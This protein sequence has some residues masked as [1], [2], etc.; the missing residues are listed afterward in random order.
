VGISEDF[1]DDLSARDLE[2]GDL[3]A[4]FLPARGML[5][6]SLQHR[7]VELLRRVHDLP[8]AA[9]RKS[10]AGIPFLHPWAN[11]LAGASYRAAGRSVS[12]DLA[13]PLLHL[14][15]GGL[16]I[17]GVSW[18]L[19][20]WE[21]IEST[22]R[23]L[24]AQL[25]WS[26]ADLLAV[27]PFRH[28]VE[29]AITLGAGALELDTT[30]RADLGGPVPVSFGFHPY[31]G[32]PELPRAEWR[33]ALPAMRRLAVDER[34]IPTGA[35]ETFAEIDSP[36]GERTFDDGFALQDERACFSLAGGGRRI[37]VELMAGYR[38]AQ[39]FAP[40]NGDCVALEPMTAPTS[41]LTGGRGLQVAAPGETFRAAFRIRV[42]DLAQASR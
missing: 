16:P 11:R 2:A 10:T 31:F 5:G 4:V 36:L 3:R 14:D 1:A 18:S 34:G 32:I 7:G 13:S 23:Q 21:V 37:T 40:R 19:L 12:L 20:A 42:E 41:A 15:A 22:P 35:E 6:A 24:A 33:L 30:L 29:L 9:A 27:F 8:A 17:H 39:V 38:Y 26:R 25:D 28:R